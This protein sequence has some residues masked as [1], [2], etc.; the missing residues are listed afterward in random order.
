MPCD[1]SLST[2]VTRAS[3]HIYIASPYHAATV[4]VNHYVIHRHFF[5]LWTSKRDKQWLAACC[6]RRFASSVFGSDIE[7]VFNR[8]PA[9]QSC[10]P[11]T[12][13]TSL[14]SLSLCRQ[15]FS[16]EVSCT[17]AE[18]TNQQPIDHP[19]RYLRGGLLDALLDGDGHPVR[20]PTQ[21]KLLLV[22]HHDVRELSGQREQPA[23]GFPV[24]SRRAYV[25]SNKGAG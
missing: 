11:V 1:S 20:Q 8:C 7:R 18:Q 10:K 21:L 22:L 15:C 14:W 5:P 2:I 4:A 13:W 9:P 12:P 19:I 16:L 24:I 25:P 3:I 6:N 23:L 17:A